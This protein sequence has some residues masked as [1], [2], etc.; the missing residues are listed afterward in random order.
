MHADVE[1]LQRAATQ[2]GVISRKD[3][4]RHLTEEQLWGRVQ[5]KLYEE[6]HPRTYRVVGAPVTWHQQLKALALWLDHGFAFSHFTAARLHGIRGFDEG[7]LE[8]TVNRRVRNQTGVV[9][10]ERVLR[11][12]EWSEETG[13]RVTTP[14]RT[15]LDIAPSLDEFELRSAMDDL[16]GR[17]KTTLDQIEDCAVKAGPRAKGR[18]RVLELVREYRGGDGPTESEL[19]I[20]MLSFCAQHGLPKPK[21]QKVIYT[22]GRKPRVDLVFEDYAVVVEGDGYAHHSS[23]EDFEKDRR[24]IGALQ[25]K[26]FAV[27]Q[28]TWHAL[29]DRPA[30]VLADV[31]AVLRSRGWDG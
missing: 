18:A 30:E 24:R 28:W 27:L 15:L 19:E 21:K 6:V 26:G 13:L 4:L 22:R 12:R 14:A 29:E 11:P 7:P 23:P 5:R 3:V 17:K 16:L 8:L 25:A 9:I 10:H 1:V 31:Q 20:R 2:F